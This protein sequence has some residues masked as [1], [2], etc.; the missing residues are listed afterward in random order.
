MKGLL[1]PRE[2]GA[3]GMLLQPFVAAA[4]L[5]RQWTWLFLPALL[6]VLVV[7][8][9]REPLLVL[10]RQSTV[11]REPRPESEIARRNVIAEALL[12]AACGIALLQQV[13]LSVLAVLGL[14]AAALSALALTMTMRNKQRSVWLQSASAF[15]LSSSALLAGQVGRG[16]LADYSVW[17]VWA[18][19][20]LHFLTGIFLVHARLDKRTGKPSAAAMQRYAWFCIAANF[21]CGAAAAALGDWP[22]LLPL[23]L[24]AAVSIGEIWWMSRPASLKEPLKRVGLRALTVSLIHTL[25]AIA[26]LW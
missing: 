5:S 24:S 16:T 20:S 3:W 25:V 14:A 22:V 8:I 6:S 10:A 4:I 7:F 15:G 18:I 2:H 26:A 13:P 19:L 11:W 21:V 17:A 1:L 12:L 23:W 9:A